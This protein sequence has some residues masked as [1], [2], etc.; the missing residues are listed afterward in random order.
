MPLRRLDD[1]ICDR[2]S[3]AV[4]IHPGFFRHICLGVDCMILER[5]AGL[6][7]GGHTLHGLN[8]LSKQLEGD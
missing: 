8:E 7:M 4:M 3:G 1:V 6:R 5:T 2:A